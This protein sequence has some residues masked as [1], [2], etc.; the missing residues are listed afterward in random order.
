M[1]DKGNI[2]RVVLGRGKDPVLTVSIV[3]EELGQV[4]VLSLAEACRLRDR[5]T[6]I[7]AGLE[8]DEFKRDVEQAPAPRVRIRKRSRA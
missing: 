3:H 2:G 5:M 6:D 1:V 7:I 8:R 4:A